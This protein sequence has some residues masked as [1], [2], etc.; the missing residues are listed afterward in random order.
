MICCK[1]GFKQVANAV[2]FLKAQIIECSFVRDFPGDHP[3][4]SEKKSLEST[5]INRRH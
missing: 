2:P 5:V 4:T 1:I 3:T